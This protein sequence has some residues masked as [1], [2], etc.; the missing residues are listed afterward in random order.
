MT[1]MI[2]DPPRRTSLGVGFD[3]TR[4]RAVTNKEAWKQ[5]IGT[6][7]VPARLALLP[8]PKSNWNRVGFSAV[9]QLSALAFFIL[10][11]LLYPEGMKTA[12]RYYSTTPL[13]TPVTEVPTP[14]PPPPPAPVKVKAPKVEVKA[15]DPVEPV[16]L[17]PQQP[18]IFANLAAPKTV[19]PKVEKLDTKAPD[20]A[21]K[22]EDAKIDVKE[23]GPKRPKDDVKVG[24]LNTGSAAPATVKAPVDK[25][26][27]GGF[28]DPNGVPGKGDANHATN[29]NR[30]GSPALPGGEGY[31]N[32]TGGKE[33]IRG[34]VASS[35]FGNGT[36]VPPSGSKKTGTVVAGGFGNATDTAAE[37]PKKKTGPTG[38][39]DTSPN[40]LDKP[41][42][43][44]TAEGR[45]LRIEG[46]VVIDL[47][48]LA[49]GTIQINR[50]VSGLG[51]GLDESAVRAAQL[52]KFK[53][54]KRENEPV[55][56]PARVRIEFRLAY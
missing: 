2:A 48:F 15:P 17:N 18:H 50:V 41:R 34:T 12:V 55:D 28:G 21:P 47:L 30:Q 24:N 9:L 20:V 38:P 56:F 31:G 35:G 10:V 23:N 44:Y 54:A 33:G 27:T 5:Q 43:E 51:H 37:A 7:P 14:P 22:F 1:I 13:A 29:V 3:A 8:E 49:N 25:V 19:Q 52:I 26:Q 16:K 6:R 53:P 4:G 39:A 46:D 11:P 42:P 40:I 36:A 45:T 32:G